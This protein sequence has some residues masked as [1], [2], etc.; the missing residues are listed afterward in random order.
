[1]SNNTNETLK[2]C[3]DCYY[4][5]RQDLEPCCDFYKKSII[6]RDLEPCDFFFRARSEPVQ[7]EE[8]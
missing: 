1:M 8:D 3:T 4:F 5:Y 6:H 2:D 7:V